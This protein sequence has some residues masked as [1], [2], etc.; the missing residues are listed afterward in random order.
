M[1]ELHTDGKLTSISLWKELYQ[2]IA[3]DDRY[4]AMLGQPGE[5]GREGEQ[6]GGERVKEGG[7]EGGRRR[8]KET[9]RDFEPIPHL[10]SLF[11]VPPLWICLNFTLKI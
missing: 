9:K 2:T 3:V 5:G 1:K 4:Y 7:R 8:E 11:Q 6:R 10:L